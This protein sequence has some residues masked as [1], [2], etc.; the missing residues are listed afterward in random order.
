MARPAASASATA[1]AAAMPERM[2]LWMALR[3]GT[4]MKPAAQPI[5]APPGKA[6]SG[7]DCQPPEVSAR[8]P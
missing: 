5:S 3:R 1:S 6:R 2:A 7:I 8:A 4:F